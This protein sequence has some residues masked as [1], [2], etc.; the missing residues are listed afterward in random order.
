MKYKELNFNGETY[1]D[2]SSIET[3]LKENNFYWLIDGEFE[4]ATIELKNNTILWDDGTW[5]NGN[6]KYGIWLG[7]TFH[8]VWENGIFEDGV[9]KGEWE[10]GIDNTKTD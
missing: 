4:N 3:I 6:W 7:G 8:G 5:L 2:Q 1:T 10:S 9:F